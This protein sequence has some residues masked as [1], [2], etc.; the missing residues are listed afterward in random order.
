MLA[1]GETA[2]DCAVTLAEV[3]AGTLVLEVS[4]WVCVCRE[5]AAGFAAATRTGRLTA[6]LGALASA[7][8]LLL[9]EV[10]PDDDELAVSLV[11]GA[12]V[13]VSVALGAMSGTIGCVAAG[14]G[15]ESA[16]WGCD[17]WASN[18]VEESARAAAIA[19]RALVRLYAWIFAIM[20]NNRPRT[21][22]VAQLSP[23]RTVTETSRFDSLSR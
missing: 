23:I 19:G 14:A 7:V 13:A 16:P 15:G 9:V 12:N 10:V 8:V 6:F 22:K 21:T 1:C 4:V 5:T 11:L 18:G 20:G 3:A 17:C 2:V